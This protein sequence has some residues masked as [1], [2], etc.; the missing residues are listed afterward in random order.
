MTALCK[1]KAVCINQ[2]FNN[3]SW[4]LRFNCN[5]ERLRAFA[6]RKNGHVKVHEEKMLLAC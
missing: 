1:P 2:I 5:V 6:R 3:N 4:H